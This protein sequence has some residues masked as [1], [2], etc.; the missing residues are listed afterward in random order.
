MSKKLFVIIISIVLTLFL[1]SL[2][3]YYL[4]L[5]NNTDTGSGGGSIFRNFFPFG[6]GAT[7]EPPVIEEP[8]VIP[9]PPTQSA[10]QKLR[11]ISAEPVAGAGVLDVKAGTLVR[12]IEKATGHIFETELFSSNQNRISNTTIPLVYDAVWGNKNN[13]LVARYLKDDN[14]TIDTYG[15]LIKEVSTS[16]ENTVSAIKLS[17]NLSQISVFGNSV[18]SLEHKP[19]S[20]LGFISNFDGTKKVQIWN[21]PVKELLAQYVNSKTVALTTKPDQNTEGF[22]FFVDTGN[23]QTKKII[24]NVFGLSTLVN[25]TATQLIFLDQKDA[26]RM[27]MFDVKSKSSTNMTPPTLPEKCV[28]SKKD[29]NIIYCAVPEEFMDRD[30]LTLWYRGFIYFTDNIWKY[31]IKNNIS[32]V[33]TSLFNE[34]REQIDVTK[35]LLSENEQYLVFVNKIDNSLWS[36]D[37]SK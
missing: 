36:L 12:H 35:L 31:D 21:S 5:Q 29:R 15:L 6:G 37:L 34:S 19:D 8:P 7:T 14:Q 32:N 13:S 23:A 25:D 27:F 20:S 2:V 3:G 26:L 11:K 1:I 33:M 18:F 16:T 17:E 9:P 30:S 10:T 4:I 24:G 22:L 28:W